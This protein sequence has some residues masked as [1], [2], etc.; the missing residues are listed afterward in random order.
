M[1]FWQEILCDKDTMNREFQA[2]QYRGLFRK[3]P[4]LEGERLILR[5]PQM[6]DAGDFYSYA[7]EKENCRYV[8]WEAHRDIAESKD[9][10]R[11]IIRRNRRGDPATF[12]ICL[13]TDQRLIGTIGFQWIDLDHRSCEVGYSIASRLWNRGLATEALGILL[14]FAFDQLQLNRIEAKHDVLNPSSG[15]VLDHLGFTREGLARKS[16]LLKGRMADMVRYA[17]LKE[18]WEKAKEQSKF[19][20]K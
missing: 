14:P 1:H 20:I 10:L 8:L 19:D 13:K 12:A 18:D 2:E 15:R 16:I 6:R 9:V 11:G 4:Q 5:S 17:L 3:L 7:R